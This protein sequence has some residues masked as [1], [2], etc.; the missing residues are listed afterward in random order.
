MK[1]IPVGTVDEVIGHA[2]TSQPVPIDPAT[3]DPD[4]ADIE[5][6]SKTPKGEGV[7]GVVTH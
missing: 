7:E 3:L 4:K 1:I 2:L 6:L 5:G